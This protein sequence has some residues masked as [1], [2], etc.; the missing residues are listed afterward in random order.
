MPVSKENHV[1]LLR[2]FVVV[3]R[4]HRYSLRVIQF[5]CYLSTTFILFAYALQL[6]N[7]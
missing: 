6:N 4:L 7:Y 5:C 3:I 2:I 1:N